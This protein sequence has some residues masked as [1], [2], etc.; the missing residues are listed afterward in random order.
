MKIREVAIISG[1]GGT[2]KTSITASFA[3]LSKNCVVADCD[4]DAPNL[5]LLLNPK[6]TERK[7]FFGEKKAKIIN[8]KCA[9]CGTCLNLCAFGVIEEVFKD[10]KLQLSVDPLLCDGCGV[11]FRFCPYSAIEF[12]EEESAYFV[13][14]NTR[15]GPMVHAQMESGSGNSGKLVGTIKEK[16]REIAKEGGFDF[17]LVDGPP[18]LGCPV[19]SSISGSSETILIT[20]PTLSAISD[21]KRIL[22]LL[23]KFKIKASVI[24]NKF[25]L[26]LALSEQI[27][28]FCQTS[29]VNFLGEISF[30]PQIPLFQSE[31]LTPV[32]A[33]GNSA[34]QIKSIYD[35]IFSDFSKED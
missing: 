9:Y 34:L 28:T 21:L 4:V 22:D 24:I 10:G 18:G 23:S 12:N 16:A 26:N 35:K 17:V 25:D 7:P 31:K 27:K 5:H 2:G 20:E 30:D 1:K 32:E 6:E 13:V 33:E 11:C 15:C 29:G 19:I 3:V 14:S 8:E